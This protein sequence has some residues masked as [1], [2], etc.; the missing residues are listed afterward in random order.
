MDRQF[1]QVSHTP[2]SACTTLQRHDWI[3]SWSRHLGSNPRERLGWLA[4]GSPKLMTRAPRQK[5]S[6]STL[7]SVDLLGG[8]ATRRQL[9]RGTWS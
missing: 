8:F 6:A 5:F 7:V 4:A 9:A 3:S 2:V 1:D